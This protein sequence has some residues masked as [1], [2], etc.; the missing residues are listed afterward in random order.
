MRDQVYWLIEI[1]NYLKR[2]GN[3]IS[4]VKAKLLYN[5]LI[6]IKLICAFNGMDNLK[7]VVKGIRKIKDVS[8]IYLKGL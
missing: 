2:K 4:S 6:E 3:E 5:D 1:L 8:E 7:S